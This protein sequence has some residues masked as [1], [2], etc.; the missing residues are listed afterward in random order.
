MY[1]TEP[2]YLPKPDTIDEIRRKRPI[3]ATPIIWLLILKEA[4]INEMAIVSVAAKDT[5]RILGAVYVFLYLT[6]YIKNNIQGIFMKTRIITAAVAAAIAVWVPNTS[7]REAVALP[8]V[9]GAEGV[10][11]GVD[12]TND[13]T[14]TVGNNQNINTNNDGG[15][16]FTTGANGTGAILFLGN[17]TVTGFTGTTGTEFRDISAGA[18]GSTVNFNGDVF[19]TT[20]RVSGTGTVNF[21]GSVRGAG[22]FDADGFLNLGA[23]KVLTGAITTS[24]ANTG[25]LTLNSNSSVTGGIGGANGLKQINLSGGNASV[26][27]AVQALGFNLGTNTL[28]ITGALTTN[29]GGTISTTL[30]GNAVYGKIV[31]TG[32]S[33]INA[34]GITVIPTVTGVLTPGTNFR[35]VEGQAGT[36]GATVT[37]L[38]SNPLYTFSSTPTTTGDVNIR[39]ELARFASP[40]ANA[41]GASLFS[42]NTQVGS[43]LLA[44]QSAVAAL[45]NA[46]SINNALTQLAPGSTNLAAPWVAGQATRLFEDLMVARMDAIQDVCC[47]AACD[48]KKSDATQKIHDCKSDERNGSWWAKGFGSVG[49]QGDVNNKNGFDTEALGL[50]IAH[51]KS[52][53]S[54]TRV[55]FGGGYAN[56]TI[57]GNNPKAQTKIDSYQVTG[58]LNY[59]PGPWF[60]QGALIA[61]MDNY[62]GSRQIIFPGVNRTASSEYNGQQYTAL[63]SAG[64]HFYFDQRVTITP[65]ASLQASHIH[66]DSYTESGAGDANLR[67]ASQDYDFIQSG[68]GVKVERV[69]QSGASTYSP[70]AHIKWLHDFNS[71]TMTQNAALTGGGAAFNVQGIQQDAN[72]YNVG[73]GVTFLSCN[74]DKDSWT[75][76]GLYDYKWNNSDYSSH[77]VSVIASLKF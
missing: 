42:T 15:G 21:N 34:G 58:Y 35:I 37:V 77:Q 40:A 13:A 76:K 6:Y 1:V 73:A 70:E 54:Q 64:Q 24:A 27:G 39:V 59:A 38:N 9:V 65:I 52:L 4:P 57:D 17:S 16:A 31:P 11:N 68:L 22:N 12:T 61:G 10:L 62:D 26:T 71:T 36:I 33:N 23:G 44:I 20:Y 32:A 29:A 25:T 8:G 45:P 75:V 60:V 46:A 53:D 50:M 43:D 7:A 69:I 47:D 5:L 28:S 19:S 30:G 72:L 56:S 51:E 14:L 48:P 55:G 66:V 3:N 74:C 41:A 67:I 63:V 49:R 18:N 2:S